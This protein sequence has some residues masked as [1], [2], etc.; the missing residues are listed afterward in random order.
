M[1]R[2]FLFGGSVLLLSSCKKDADSTLVEGQVVDSQKGQPVAGTSVQVEQAGTSGGF[3]AVG[4]V[5]PTDGQGH[6]SFHFEAE[7]TPTYIV[8]AGSPLGYF[9][10][11]TRAPTLKAGR[12][13]EQLRV[14]VLAPAWVRLQLVDEPPKSRVSMY[15]SGFQGDG[16]RLNYPRDTTFIRYGLAQYMKV[17]Y[18]VITNNQGVDAQYSQQINPAA[19]DTVT[20][21]IA[22]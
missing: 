18:W 12:K 2:S 4:P 10:D 3:T 13:N 22:F 20:V 11:W 7:A 8:R 16:Q 17:I 6:F 21:R 1:L 9:T 15:V 5:Y 14:P 19:L